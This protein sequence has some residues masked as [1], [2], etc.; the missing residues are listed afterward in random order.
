[1]AQLGKPLPS[2]QV[3]IPDPWVLGLSPTSG[4]LLSGESAPPSPSVPPH[5]SCSWSLS[6]KFLKNETEGRLGGAVVKRL[7]SAQG[8][9]PA[10]RAGVPHQAP[11]LGACFFLSLS[12]A[13]FPLSLAVSVT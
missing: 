11:R 10:I 9:I 4:S 5:C 6:N 2:A 12:P 13:V 3:M 1:M 7:S 8:V